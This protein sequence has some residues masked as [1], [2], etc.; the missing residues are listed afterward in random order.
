MDTLYNLCN[1]LCNLT[2]SML[3]DCISILVVSLVTCTD[4]SCISNLDRH[5]PPSAFSAHDQTVGVWKSSGSLS[6]IR[7]FQRQFR[8]SPSHWQLFKSSPSTSPTGW[9]IRWQFDAKPDRLR[10]E[11]LRFFTRSP[12][13]K[14]LRN[15]HQNCSTTDDESLSIHLPTLRWN[16]LRLRIMENKFP[17][18]ANFNRARK[19]IHP[20]RS[21]NPSLFSLRSPSILQQN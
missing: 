15:C 1:S 19:G 9:R 13:R 12:L 7:T 4:I 10:F 17:L 16:L 11:I 21:H 6:T 20:V 18:L 8:I 3:F 5:A 2:L 14:T